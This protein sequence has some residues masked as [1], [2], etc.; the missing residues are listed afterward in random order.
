MLNEL[1]LL[2]SSVVVDRGGAA[3]PTVP[4]GRLVLLL[5]WGTP[6]H[7]GRTRIK[8]GDRES[9]PPEM[10]G[11]GGSVTEIVKNS[12]S[13]QEVAHLKYQSGKRICLKRKW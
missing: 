13:K 6:G 1:S 11:V 8:R 7:H 3:L 4:G 12:T 2:S 10:A 5:S 9:G